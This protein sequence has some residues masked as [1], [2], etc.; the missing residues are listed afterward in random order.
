MIHSLALTVPLLFAAADAT[1]EIEGVRADYLEAR[2]AT[3]FAGACHY[4]SEYT[5]LGREGVA[6]WS[7]S[8]GTV[9][10]VSLAGLVLG[11]A[12]VGDVNLD[13]AGSDRRSVVFLPRDLEAPVREAALAWLRARQGAF[14]GTVVEVRAAELTFTRDTDGFDLRLGKAV[15]LEGALLPN[16]DCCSQRYRVWYE[17]FDGRVQAPVVGEA[18][19]FSCEDERLGRS[20]TSRGVNCVFSGSLVE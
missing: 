5:T 11:V 17:P 10:G 12:V 4:G 19:R 16:R 3:V 20:W 1:P 8:A 13:V 7:F 6:A 15:R 14:V 9:D 18:A 2:T